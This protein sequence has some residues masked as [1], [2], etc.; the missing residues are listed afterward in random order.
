[1]KIEA[2][3]EEH[4]HHFLSDMQKEYHG[5]KAA[6]FI[7]EKYIR[8]G[9]ISD[10]EDKILKTQILDSLKIVGVVIPFLLIPGASILMPI[11]IK[12][13]DKHNIELMPSTFINN[14]QAVN[15]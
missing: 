10:E 3:I 2:I 14:K 1:M 8:E 7:I 9:K 6:C 15:T 4:I 13:A 5:D 11:I 12:V